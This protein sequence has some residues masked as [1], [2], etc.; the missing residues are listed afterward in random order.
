MTTYDWAFLYGEN[1][2][3]HFENIENRPSYVDNPEI[4]RGNQGDTGLQIRDFKIYDGDVDE[5]V[6]TKHDFA[7]S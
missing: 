3:G 1:V 2:G 6:T 4:L 7:L 5:N